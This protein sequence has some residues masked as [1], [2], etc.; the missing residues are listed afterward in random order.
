[1]QQDLIDE[2]AD[3]LGGTIT[4]KEVLPDGSGFAIMSLP[5]PENHWIYGDRECERFVCNH[6]GDDVFYEPPPM[7]MRMGT[8]NPH[9]EEFA[10]M[11]RRAARYAIRAS[12]MNGK[13][14][15]FGPDALVQNIVIGM[16]G[17]HTPDGLTDD[18][19]ANPTGAA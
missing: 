12:T 8:N 10:E 1:M 5:L 19:W 18:E 4:E 2:M 3:S 9:R 15:D 7:P 17:Y 16:L 14:M 6:E 13:E 11:L